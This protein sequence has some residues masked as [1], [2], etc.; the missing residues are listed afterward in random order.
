MFYED[1]RIV[2]KQARFIRS[3]ALE[4]IDNFKSKKLDDVEII[5]ALELLLQDKDNNELHQD[6]VKKAISILNKED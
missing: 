3:K 2:R 6:I 5:A 4:M 1:Q